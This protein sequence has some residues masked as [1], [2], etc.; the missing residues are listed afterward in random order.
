[1]AIHPVANIILD[2]LEIQNKI[3]RIAFQIYETFLGEEKI[4]IAGIV[5]N[6]FIFAKKL[7]DSLEAISDIQVLSCELLMDKRN[8]LR[9]MQTSLSPQQY[10]NKGIVLAD[11]VLNSG[12]TLMYG[13]K[14]FLHVPI[15]KLKTTV[16]VNRNHKKYPIKADFKGISLSTSLQEHVRVVLGTAN[17]VAV[18]E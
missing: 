6:G 1:M 5:G 12:A 11:D 9:S 15:K 17:D 13:V 2:H 16:L 4:V 18:L 14:H 8:P 7:K 3:K 10:K